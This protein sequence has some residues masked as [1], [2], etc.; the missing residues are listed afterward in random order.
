MDSYK[1]HTIDTFNK[2]KTLMSSQRNLYDNLSKKELEVLE[3]LKRLDDDI[4]IASSDKGGTIVIQ[5]VKLYISKVERQIIPKII[6]HCQM[7]Q[8]K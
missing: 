5:D 3:Q 4:I 1:H 8:R 2:K 7:T 6:D